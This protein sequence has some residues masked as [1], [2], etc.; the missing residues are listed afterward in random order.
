MG[1]DIF[2]ATETD[3]TVLGKA[4]EAVL[5]GLPVKLAQI[6]NR[7]AIVYPN[8][9][10]VEADSV[11]WARLRFKVAKKGDTLTDKDIAELLLRVGK[12]APWVHVEKLFKYDGQSAFTKDQGEN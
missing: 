2:L 10:G 11:D 1:V 6:S 12:K 4:V 3:P 5:G 8:E 7:G 9:H